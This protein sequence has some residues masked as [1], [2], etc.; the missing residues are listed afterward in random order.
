MGV[1]ALMGVTPDLMGV[2]ARD[3][4]TDLIGVTA[5]APAAGDAIRTGVAERADATGAGAA[6][7]GAA[8]PP[9]TGE[10]TTEE[11]ALG[12]SAEKPVRIGEK[13]MLG[14]AEKPVRMGETTS[15]AAAR[16]GVSERTAAPAK[17]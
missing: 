3:G 2:T 12:A 13:P 4:V 5:C 15:C 1:T 17:K 6:A 7:H 10:T 8:A 14:A 11:P 16:T 9:R